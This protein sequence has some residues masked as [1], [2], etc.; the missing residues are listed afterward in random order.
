MTIYVRS[1]S[2]LKS[3]EA[4]GI[5]PRPPGA[6]AIEVPGLE[7]AETADWERRLSRYYFSCGCDLGAAMLLGALIIYVA[8]LVLRPGGFSSAGWAELGGAVGVGLV[9]AVVGKLAGLGHARI[10]FRATTEALVSH[11]EKTTPQSL[12]P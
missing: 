10:R 12:R 6:L 9:A 3:L 4:P 5:W 1:I 2:D 11:L 8:I 7:R